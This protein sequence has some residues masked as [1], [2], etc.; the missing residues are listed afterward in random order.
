MSAVS[1]TTAIGAQK[2]PPVW[3]VLTLLGLNLCA[4]MSFAWRQEWPFALIYLGAAL[5]QTGTVWWMR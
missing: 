2:P 3:F 1:E 4:A 5:I